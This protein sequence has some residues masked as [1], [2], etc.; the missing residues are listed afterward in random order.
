MQEAGAVIWQDASGWNYGRNA[1]PFDPQYNYLR[2]VDYCS[3]ASL[4]LKKEILEH[5]DGLAREFAPAYYEDTDLC[6]AIRH[7]L[8]LKVIYQP[9]SEVIHYEGVSSGTSTDSGV[10]QYQLVNA[11]K[12]QQ[13]WH[14]V[15]QTSQY[16]VNRGIANLPRAA[17]KY[18][19]KQTILVIDSYMP[20]YDKESGSQ[21]LFHLL[22]ILR[23]LNYH[24]IFAADNGFKDQPYTSEL[25]NLQ[26]E[27]IYTDDGYGEPPEAQITARLPLVD[28]A[29]ICR[30]ELNE[31]YLP[32]IRTHN[33]IKTIYD[34]ID[35]HYLRMKR[36]WEISATKDIQ[37]ATEWVDMQA[38]ELKIAHQ[39]D[40]T[41]TVT[42]VEQ[43]ILQQQGI[44]SVA[45]VPNIH[46]DRTRDYPDWDTSFA[47]RQNILF[48]GGY[49]HPPNVD[50]VLWLCREIMPLVWR[51]LPEVKVTLL[52]SNPTE[53]VQ[54][55]G[56]DRVTVTGYISDVSDYFLSHRIFV[57]PLRYGAGMKGKIG[58]SLEYSLPV[59]STEV[60]IEGMHLTHNKNVLEANTAEEFAQQILQLYQQ[61]KLW[62][63]LASNCQE[64]I[65]SFNPEA[66]RQNLS[67][68]LE[69]LNINQ[70]LQV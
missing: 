31:K 64:A 57:S 59:I 13:K 38:R 9:K 62:H 42:S 44:D 35:L 43:Q 53:Q 58:Q 23:E 11:Q 33:N 65:A 28:F 49:N 55:L 40:L 12:F 10:K 60:G 3:G 30:P 66:I 24:V 7:Q 50:A 26:I 22:K 21:R 51:Q 67:Q 8:G 2:E 61:E 6:F 1:N 41:I 18:Q 68:L 36:A 20:C 25:Q 69:Q 48:I 39:A 56:S 16:L 19:G 32:L 54:N 47:A 14:Q 27:T 70:T 17:R 29:W 5:L 46:L 4:M 37:E 63:D 45:V 15:L 52:G 34:T